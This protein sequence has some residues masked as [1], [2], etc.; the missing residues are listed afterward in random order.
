MRLTQI[1]AS[2]VLTGTL[3]LAGTVTAHAE[4]YC[5]GYERIYP[6]A[7]SLFGLDDTD[8]HDLTLR[9][10][11]EQMYPCDTFWLEGT[12]TNQN[13]IH[14]ANFY[15]YLEYYNPSNGTY[16]TINQGLPQG[17]PGSLSISIAPASTVTF[18]LPLGIIRGSPHNASIVS[19]IRARA[20][21]FTNGPA[22]VVNYS[23]T[24]T[25]TSRP[26]YNRGGA[27]LSSAL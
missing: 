25:I 6:I 2:I 26:G 23:L 22:F 27:A 10:P 15:L 20:Q 7:E 24:V 8:Y 3:S 14:G 1:L 19:R 21:Q 16:L 9:P 11:D 5:P 12:A 17:G 18:R 13:S 4:P